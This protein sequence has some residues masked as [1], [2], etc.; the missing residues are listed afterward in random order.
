MRKINQELVALRNISWA[1]SV[2]SLANGQENKL[3]NSVHTLVIL[4]LASDTEYAKTIS[5][6]IHKG[7]A[8]IN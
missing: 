4:S 6:A 5:G 8:D 3:A 1:A 7:F 2:K